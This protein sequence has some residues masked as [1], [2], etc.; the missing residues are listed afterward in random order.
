[1]YNY[2]CINVTVILLTLVECFM[3]KL[4]LVQHDEVVIE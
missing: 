1:M 4:P 3:L 2:T